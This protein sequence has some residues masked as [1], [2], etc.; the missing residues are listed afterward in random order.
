MLNIPVKAEAKAIH[1]ARKA[2]QALIL[3]LVVLVGLRAQIQN[4][5]SFIDD[6][7]PLGGFGSIV[8]WVKT[9]LTPLQQGDYMNFVIL[10]VTII[11]TLLAG[12][13]F[14][15][16]ICPLGTLQDWLYKFRL[17]FFKKEIVLPK[18]VDE[19]LRYDLKYAFLALILIKVIVKG[20]TPAFVEKAPFRVMFNFSFA[21]TAAVIVFV[22]FLVFNMLIEKFWCKYLCPQG[23]FIALLSKI[24]IIKVRRTDKCSNCNRC[25]NHCSLGLQK[26]GDLGCTNC[27]ECVNNCHIPQKALSL[28]VV[29]KQ[30]NK[31]K[32]LLPVAGVTVGLILVF[33]ILAMGM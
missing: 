2:I 1:R 15:G 29:E 33:G 32:F 26:I 28:N 22:L 14:C 8:N 30:T 21:S 10:V 20:H 3:V 12:G 19:F 11:I 24:S 23:A 6:Y 27:L 7:F 18:S 9:G 31:N 16:W 25:M 4:T 13:V 5:G 17:K